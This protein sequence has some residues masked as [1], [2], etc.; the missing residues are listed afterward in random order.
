MN[1]TYCGSVISY[2]DQKCKNCGATNDAYA[3]QVAGPSTSTEGMARFESSV[4]SFGNRLAQSM[5]AHREGAPGMLEKLIRGA[6]LDGEIYRQ[7]VAD[8][9]GSG[10]AFLVLVLTNLA[11]LLGGFLVLLRMHFFLPKVELLVLS[12]VIGLLAVVAGIALMAALSQ[13]VTRHKMSFGEM[14]RGVAYA[15]SPAL[16]RVLPVLGSLLSLW[17]ILTTVVAVREITGSDLSKAIGLS[18]IGVVGMI[19]VSASLSPLLIAAMG[20]SMSGSFPF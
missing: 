19:I 4:S 11:G 2:T 8:A 3:P 17:C 12:A 10:S 16:C 7:A 15:Q 20:L 6:F 18:V 5:G 1:C 9:G 14:M 13:A